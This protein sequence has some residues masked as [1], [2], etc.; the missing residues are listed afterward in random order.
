M[1]GADA[2]PTGRRDKW[3]FGKPCSMTHI[4]TIRKGVQERLLMVPLES[5]H[6]PC[7]RDA[8][9]IA[10]VQSGTDV[11]SRVGTFV[12]KS[13]PKVTPLAA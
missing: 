12:D 9:G 13:L 11:R 3:T 1:R 10:V 5:V 6:S 8:A 7:G 4:F 2:G